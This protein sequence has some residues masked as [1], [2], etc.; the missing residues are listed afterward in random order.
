MQQGQSGQFQ[1]VAWVKQQ[2]KE[3]NSTL[4]GFWIGMTDIEKEG[5]FKWRSNRTLSSDVAFYW[6]WSE[7]NNDAEVEPENCVEVAWFGPYINNVDCNRKRPSVCQKRMSYTIENEHLSWW[8]M[9]GVL[10][11]VVLY[12][13]GSLLYCGYKIKVRKKANI[14]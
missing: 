13:I 1:L 3:S 8:V 2:N 14:E 7:P 11:G 6:G 9:I 5:N 4:E 10:G 12:L